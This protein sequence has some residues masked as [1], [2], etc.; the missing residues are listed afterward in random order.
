MAVIKMPEPPRDLAATVEQRPGLLNVQ[1]LVRL[2]RFGKTAIY[3][4]V[5]AGRIPYLRFDS[6]IRFDPIA[7]ADWMREHTVPLAA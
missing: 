2:T 1:D 6:S 7:I 3:D 4:M 5:A